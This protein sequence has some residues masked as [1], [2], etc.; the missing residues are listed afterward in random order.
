MV[1]A[2]SAT[3]VPP[4]ASLKQKGKT[5][6]DGTSKKI[7]NMA[8]DKFTVTFVKKDENKRLRLERI[9]AARS[10]LSHVVDSPHEVEGD[11]NWEDD[12]DGGD[13]NPDGRN[14]DSEARANADDESV[15]NENVPRGAA[16]T[17]KP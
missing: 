10:H 2:T 17:S 12:S 6:D 14:D 5:K 13:V 7:T 15:D 4:I 11:T 8:W 16:S 3:L 9:A 1:I